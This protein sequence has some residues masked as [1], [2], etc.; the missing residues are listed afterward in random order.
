MNAV[1]LATGSCEA[2]GSSMSISPFAFEMDMS[3]ALC[4]GRN[5]TGIGAG[6]VM[7]TSRT[8]RA[9]GTIW[10]SNTGRVVFEWYGTG[11]N[12]VG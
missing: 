1:S 4:G 12:V 2:A 6:R 7:G 9:A 10:A 8:L 5:D 11:R 3:C